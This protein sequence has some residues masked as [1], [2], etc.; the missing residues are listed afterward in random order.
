MTPE[1]IYLCRLEEI[2]EQQAKGFDIQTSS[3]VRHI[4]LVNLKNQ[5]Y[6][7]I[8]RCPHTGVNLDWMPDQFLDSSGILIQCATHGALFRIEDG[9]CT[10]GPCSGDT[11]TPVTLKIQDN[12][13]FFQP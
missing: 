13:V 5:L 6:G 3:G 12:C 10:F 9:L 11:L 8:N 7:Y 4:F 1:L 2:P